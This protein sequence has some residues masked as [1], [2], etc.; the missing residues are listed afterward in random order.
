VRNH[1]R[2][3][4][5]R[6]RDRRSES[7]RR[8]SPPARREDSRAVR[9]GARGNAI[10]HV[11]QSGRYIDAK[12]RPSPISGY[13]REEEEV[14]QGP[15]AIRPRTRR[16]RTSLP[17]SGSGRAARWYCEE[18]WPC[19][20][21]S[22]ATTR[23][24]SRNALRLLVDVPDGMRLSGLRSNSPSC[25]ESQGRGTAANCPGN[26]HAT[27]AR[28][29]PQWDHLLNLQE[30]R[31]R[32][33]SRRSDGKHRTTDQGLAAGPHLSHCSIR[34]SASTRVVAALRWY[35]DSFPA[36]GVNRVFS[37]RGNAPHDLGR[38]TEVENGISA[39]WEALTNIHR[40]FGKH[41]GRVKPI[42]RVR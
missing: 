25:F 30:T 9:E 14:S 31:R 24:S 36:R 29:W 11:R 23:T 34:P 2:I 19:V 20:K 12:R 13:S 3:G 6:L 40:P 7:E 28:P 38:F 41:R 18:G 17:R 39:S 35:I 27:T 37:T 21:S 1:G 32:T 33:T 15:S 8:R 10:D 42:E 4:C 22:T 16:R 5:C 26:F